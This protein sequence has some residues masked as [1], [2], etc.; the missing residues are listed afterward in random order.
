MEI[1]ASVNGPVPLWRAGSL[2]KGTGGQTDNLD[3]LLN[4]VPLVFIH[5]L[6]SSCPT[7]SILSGSPGQST[8]SDDPGEH[9][10]RGIAH[11]YQIMVPSQLQ[12]PTFCFC[13][14]AMKVGD[15]RG[16]LSVS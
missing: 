10:V 5:S 6:L 11:I 8:S 4:D 3:P 1:S 16:C 2:F 14:L 12:L 9:R 13:F 7:L 15:D